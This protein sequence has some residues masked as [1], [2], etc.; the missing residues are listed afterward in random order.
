MDN[1]KQNT[2][3]VADGL[4]I[5]KLNINIGNVDGLERRIFVGKVCRELAAKKKGGRYEK[6]KEILEKQTVYLLPPVV[7]EVQGQG[8]G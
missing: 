2:T 7:L 4:P 6:E 8:Q 5:H 1:N 3:N